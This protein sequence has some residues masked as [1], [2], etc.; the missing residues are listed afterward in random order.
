MAMTFQP[1]STKVATMIPRLLTMMLFACWS[2]LIRLPR[3]PAR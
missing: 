2:A 1:S 3:T